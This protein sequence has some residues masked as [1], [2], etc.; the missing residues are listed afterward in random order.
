[1]EM[2]LDMYGEHIKREASESLLSKLQMDF[3]YHNFIAI[4]LLLRRYESVTKGLKGDGK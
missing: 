3:E 4:S 2:G 1:M